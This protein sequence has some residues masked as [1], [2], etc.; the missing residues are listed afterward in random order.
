MTRMGRELSLVLVGAGILTAGY[1]I[2]PSRDEE[3]ENKADDL[4]AERVGES[5]EERT[6]R[7]HSHIPLLLFVHSRGYAG[8]GTGPTARASS[9]SVRKGGFGATGRAFG[10]ATG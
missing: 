7:R 10:G 3:L 5:E 4:A 9:P 8:A 6:H 1:F 2:A